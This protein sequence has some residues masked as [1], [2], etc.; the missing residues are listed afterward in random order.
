MSK[1]SELAATLKERDKRALEEMNS[2]YGGGPTIENL[3]ALA[4]GRA[5]DALA[6]LLQVLEY[7]DAQDKETHVPKVFVQGD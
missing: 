5:V 2:Y 3:I 7:L 6:V 1:W 4:D